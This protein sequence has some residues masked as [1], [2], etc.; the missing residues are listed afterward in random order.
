MVPFILELTDVLLDS[1]SRP[2]PTD[3]GAVERVA[4]LA[5]LGMNGCEIRVDCSDGAFRSTE[6]GEL[7]MVAIPY[8]PTQE[9]VPRQKRFSPQGD[10][11]GGV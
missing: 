2:G 3:L 7:R 4:S 10:E 6:A 1:L 9:D 11:P 8:G 5:R